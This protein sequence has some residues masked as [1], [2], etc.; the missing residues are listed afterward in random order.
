MPDIDNRKRLFSP[1]ALSSYV[2]NATPIEEKKKSLGT[3]TRAAIYGGNA[4][5]AISTI[6]ALKS[7]AG[8]EGNPLYGKDPSM[9]RIALTKGLAALGEDFI[10]SKLASNG[11]DKLAK[12]IG[13]GLGALNGGVAI[14]N[15]SKGRGK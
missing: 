8:Q 3:P 5:D 14:S 15:F 13:L 1:G 10:L 9:G 12:G 7:G 2:S 6:M 4:V 11:H